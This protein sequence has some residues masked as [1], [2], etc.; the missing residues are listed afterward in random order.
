FNTFNGITNSPNQTTLE[1]FVAIPATAR[2]SGRVQDNSGANVVGVTL[3][4][5]ATINGN[6]YQT[7]D[8][9]TDNSGNYSM[10]VASGQW[11]LQFLEGGFSDNLDAHG[12]VDLFTPHVV[13]I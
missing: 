4:G 1:N 9:T 5:N 2:I 3:F 13:A 7:L 8:S 6:N 10:A 11:S 12:Y